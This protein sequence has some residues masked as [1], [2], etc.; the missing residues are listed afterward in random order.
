MTV[1]QVDLTALIFK[2]G[3]D[4]PTKIAFYALFVSVMLMYVV[5]IRSFFGR[6]LGE[7]T[8]DFQ[9]G[10]DQQHESALY[11][12]LVLWRCSLA[13]MTGVILLPI[14]SMIFGRDL[15]APATG[16]QLYRSR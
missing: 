3:L 6:T 15:L 8:F 9:M 5:V 12:V 4:V 13:I 14:L 2:V 11:P 1:T 7:W 16:L 10:N